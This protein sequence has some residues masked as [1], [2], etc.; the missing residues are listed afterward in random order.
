MEFVFDKE[1]SQRLETVL[2][3]LDPKTHPLVQPV[4]ARLSED[5]KAFVIDYLPRYLR[6]VLEVRIILRSIPERVKIHDVWSQEGE[7]KFVDSAAHDL[8]ELVG[9][10]DG[11]NTTIGEIID[12][13]E[14][15]PPPHIAARL[16]EA[17][18][19][20]V[21]AADVTPNQR[22]EFDKFMQE[23]RYIDNVFFHAKDGLEEIAM[24]KM[25][26]DLDRELVDLTRD[27]PSN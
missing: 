22:D 5:Q 26:G 10:P 25:F 15:E 3:E 19:S 24:E 12:L 23:T 9:G 16:E 21:Q 7:T 13:C 6:A 20:M 4:L 2:T 8:Y 1:T 11:S 18:I 14:C 17:N 27:P